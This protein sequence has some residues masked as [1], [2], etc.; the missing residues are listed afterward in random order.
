[1]KFYLNR[2]FYNNEK[3][4]GLFYN[5]NDFAKYFAQC[6]NLFIYFIYILFRTLR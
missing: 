4:L 1:M 6:R 3:L 5:K 2:R